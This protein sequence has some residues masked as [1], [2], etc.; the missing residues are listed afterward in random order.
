MKSWP[1]V[2]AV[3]VVAGVV[4]IVIGTIPINRREARPV[5]GTIHSAGVVIRDVDHFTFDRLYN[6]GIVF[7][8]N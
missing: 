3:V 5:P 2:E 4:V 7:M 6:D 8:Q 1:P